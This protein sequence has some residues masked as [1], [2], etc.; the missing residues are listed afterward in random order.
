MI[1]HHIAYKNNVINFL[2]I[3]CDSYLLSIQQA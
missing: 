1:K 3:V 2:C